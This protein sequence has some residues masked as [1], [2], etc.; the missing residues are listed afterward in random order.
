[1]VATVFFEALDMARNLADQA[2]RISEGKEKTGLVE[3]S[4]GPVCNV[5][6]VGFEPTHPPPEWIK[7]SGHL[8]ISES[9]EL[10]SS[11]KPDH[12]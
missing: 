11:C 3:G 9:F 1:M 10:R 5:P 8:R 6:P 7:R 4:T 12:K 2:I